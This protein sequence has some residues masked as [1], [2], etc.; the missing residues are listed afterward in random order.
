MGIRESALS[1]RQGLIDLAWPSRC[2]VCE[3]WL[4]ETSSSRGEGE[5]FALSRLIHRE[6]LESL[7][8][9]GHA[10]DRPSNAPASCPVAWRYRDDSRFFR[11]LH[12]IKYGGQ[13]PLIE[14]LCDSFAAWAA[15]LLPPLS[16]GRIVPLPEDPLRL[17]RR[18]HS[19]PR[20][21][22]AALAR[23][24]NLP[25]VEG[26]LIRRKAALGLATLAQKSER[27]A[28]LKSVFGVSRLAELPSG[29]PLIL[30]DDQV[31]TGATLA[32]CVLLLR[33]RGHPLLALALAGAKAAPRRV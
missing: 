22:A 31:T 5:D 27:E 7:S 19:L 23:T 16:T 2:P 29:V 11:I 30:V 25:L 18:G 28:A 26:I 20:A 10:L 6:C 13:Y 3:S 14:A 8:P 9:S 17:A 1:W 33:S 21:L 12:A 24:A 4:G 15:P 32:A